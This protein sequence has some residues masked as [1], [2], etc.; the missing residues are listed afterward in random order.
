MQT[1][2]LYSPKMLPTLR[3]VFVFVMVVLLKVAQLLRTMA[4]STQDTL[5]TSYLEQNN[6]NN[7]KLLISLPSTKS[8][9][10][11]Q[12]NKRGGIQQ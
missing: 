5:P 3:F 4:F 6:T 9:A 7:N 11:G 12:S 2:A 8:Q 10:D 1:S